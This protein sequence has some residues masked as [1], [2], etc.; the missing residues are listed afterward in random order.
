MAII[1]HIA[2]LEVTV[3]VDGEI[4]KEYE[5]IGIGDAPPQLEDFHIPRPRTGTK[6]R[7]QSIRED[8][9]P[10]AASEAHPDRAPYVAKYFEGKPG[11]AFA[12]RFKRSPLFT[13][14]GHHIATQLSVDNETLSLRHDETVKG[15]G[16]HA[17]KTWFFTAIGTAVNQDGGRKHT[18][19]HFASLETHEDELVTLAE[20]QAQTSACRKLGV[21]R[22]ECFYMHASKYST[23]R[24]RVDPAF[25]REKDGVAQGV[26]AQVSE[27]AIKGKSIDLQAEHKPSIESYSYDWFEVSHDNFM[28]EKRRPFDVFEFRYRTMEGLYKEGIVP[29]PGSVQDL[30]QSMSEAEARRLA[31]AYLEAQEVSSRGVKREREPDGISLSDEAFQARYKTRRLDSGQFEVDLTD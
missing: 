15:V 19:F 9:G 30:A 31:Q 4:A 10:A 20:I 29:R 17:A 11:A 18:D 26:P 22:L 1:E 16:N 23:M 6:R 28:E 13:H 7:W 5:P 24:F 14:R 27:K 8:S 12:V 25:N 2:G 3:E 21:I